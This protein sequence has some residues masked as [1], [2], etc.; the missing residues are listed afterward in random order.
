MLRL[1]IAAVGR[2]K[3]DAEKTLS[4][5]Y[6]ERAQKAGA[7]LGLSLAV[8]ETGESRA[9]RAADRKREEASA[10]MALVPHGAILAT[11][12]EHGTAIT[13]EA[14]A[15]RIGRW[16]DGGTAEIAFLI[17]GADGLDPELVAKAS[18]VLAFGPMTWPHQFVRAML[19][20]Q[21]YRAF[22]ILAGHPYHR[23]G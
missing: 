15:D 22:T 8:R 9:A 11:L 18:L 19:S 3:A 4:E 2:L 6:V 13:S 20:E 21:I 7:Q 12:D 5:R 17:G 23:G 10:L 14:F 1:T 16:R